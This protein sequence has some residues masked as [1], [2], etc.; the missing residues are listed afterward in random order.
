[1]S[2][3]DPIERNLARVAR[4]W[5]W[6]EFLR[7]SATLGSVVVLL[8]LLLGAGVALGWISSSVFVILC[9]TVL[10]VV[11]FVVW[12]VVGLVLLVSD[13][14]R[15]WLA[16]ALERAHPPLLDRLNTL[17][18]LERTAPYSMRNYAG[19]I[20][21]QTR[22]LLRRR[23]PPSPFSPRRTL[24]HVTVFALILLATILFYDYFQPWEKLRA[25]EERSVEADPQREPPLDI[26]PPKEDLDEDVAPWGEIRIS[27]PG[28]DL[29]VT[30]LGTVELQIEVAANE[31][32]ESVAWFTAVN[33]GEETRHALPSPPDPRYAV[34]RPLLDVKSH[35]VD[36]WDVLSYYARA[37]T[38]DG[39]S[40]QSRVYFVQVFPFREELEK[41][42]GGTDDQRRSLLNELSGMIQRQQEV[43]RRTDG[44]ERVMDDSKARAERRALAQSEADLAG[45]VGH[46][47]ARCAGQ[48]DSRVAAGLTGRLSRAEG[49]L[50][51][52]A[53]KLRNATLS[54]ARREESA[55]LAELVASRKYLRQCMSGSPDA[56]ARESPVQEPA[57]KRKQVW[58]FP[59]EERVAREL[60]RSLLEKQRDI[61]RRSADRSSQPRLAREE[62]DLRRSLAKFEQDHP[63]LARQLE[64]A[65]SAARS[66]LQ[67]A[68]QSLSRRG[69]DAGRNAAA[70]TERLEELAAALERRSERERLADAYRLKRELDE[71]RQLHEGLEE[72]PDLL[73]GR[74]LMRNTEDLKSTIDQLK[75]LAEQKPTSDDFGP[76]LR[77]E[78]SDQNRKELDA[79]CDSLC[80]AGGAG[81]KG[82]AAGALKGTLEKIARAF[83]ASQPRL[84]AELQTQDALEENAGQAM[85]H[86]IRQLKRLAQDPRLSSQDEARLRRESVANLQSGVQGA[87][88]NNERSRRALENVQQ[89]LED[90]AVPVDER[91][92]QRLLD[93][94]ERLSRERTLTDKRPQEEPGLT[95]TDPSRLPPAYREAI[96]RYFRRL[97]EAR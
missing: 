26:P 13:R 69:S 62:A 9:L 57:G 91:L 59:Y 38:A 72:N 84:L 95:H 41:L 34:Y 33:A 6:L 55:A 42:P 75:Q 66:A 24:A 47:G 85:E 5:R 50:R 87:Y 22:T 60:I 78:L 20:E 39:R 68:A 45:A 86:G 32:L 29:R 88:G 80:K 37:T 93:V 1:M 77:E 44:L 92:I 56:V 17:V 51:E 74:E 36:D 76:E 10:G 73:T 28:R 11:G 43:I 63:D 81:A 2:T 79:Q 3:E 58:D 23:P 97:S 25:T 40:Y 14:N 65:C 35:G 4:Q 7:R 30:R 82:R 70:A 83:S 15:G 8:V 90:P 48:V 46:V 94:V 12:A 67:R 71:Q 21:D 18:F 16:S 89:A 53:D 52:A 19:R 31:S 64:R 54:D 49:A 27:E 96:E 61:E